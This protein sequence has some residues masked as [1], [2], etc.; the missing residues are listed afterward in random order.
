LTFHEHPKNVAAVQFSANGQWLA[1]GGIGG[2]ILVMT[3]PEGILVQR[4]KGHQT[5]VTSLTISADGKTLISAG[6][7]GTI[8]FWDT[9]TWQEQKSIPIQQ[10]GTFPV[11]LSPDGKHLAVGCEYMVKIFDREDGRQTD[12]LPVEAK[13]V[14]A[15][16][17]SPDGKYLASGSADKRVRVWAVE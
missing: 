11:Q 10:R 3:V 12:E 17:F 9:D 15:V 1:S 2:D 14:Y 6:Y 8:R 7:E 4:L 13:G 16:A 5:A